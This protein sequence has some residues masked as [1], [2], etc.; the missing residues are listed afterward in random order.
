METRVSLS[1]KHLAE[2]Q[3]LD[4]SYNTAEGGEEDGYDDD[5]WEGEEETALADQDSGAPRLPWAVL[6]KT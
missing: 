4:R 6:L 2:A 3:E 5:D 1:R